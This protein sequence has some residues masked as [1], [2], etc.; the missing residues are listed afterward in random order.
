MKGVLKVT[1]YM[2]IYNNKKLDGL[3]MLE[4]STILHIRGLSYLVRYKVYT[5]C[6][7]HTDDRET[8]LDS[9]MFLVS[10][11]TFNSTIS[12]YTAS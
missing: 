11:I 10:V 4:A 3:E 2:Y 8:I 5:F 6:Q 1:N 12:Y 7:V 9:L